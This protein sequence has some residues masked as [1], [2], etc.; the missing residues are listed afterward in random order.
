MK[1]RDALLVLGAVILAVGVSAILLASS[2]ANAP[3]AAAGRPRIFFDARNPPPPA[4]SVTE[5]Q[6]DVPG[7]LRLVI[8]LQRGLS[9]TARDA[10]GY[11][12]T[13]LATSGALVLARDPVVNAYRASLGGWGTQLRVF[14]SGLA[15]IGVAA[16]AAALAWIVFLGS[17][18]GLRSAAL[19]AVPAALQIGLAVF[20]VA[21]A[22][23]GLVALVGFAA[24][25]WRLGDALLRLRGL[26]RFA[27]SV[28]A[29]LIAL[30][31]ATCI[32]LTWQLPYVGAVA[33]LAAIAYALGAVIT[34]RLTNTIRSQA[35][36]SP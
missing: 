18:S 1:Q 3:S 11:L 10:A 6:R 29:P 17:V 33:L 8:P 15:V 23:T 26:R 4:R 32:Y 25:S 19:I 20:S 27:T 28:P 31:G 2:F 12:L 30:L 35:A 16:S 24:A 14:G 9:D 22:V 5:I 21:V 34:A 36:T 7:P 13:L